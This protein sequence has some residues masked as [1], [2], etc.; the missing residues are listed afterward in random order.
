[1]PNVK[2]NF[3]YAGV[4][5]ALIAFV[6]VSMLTPL[7]ASFGITALP[8]AGWLCAVI[9]PLVL[10]LVYEIYKILYSVYL[11]ARRWKEKREM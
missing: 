4:I 8:A 1:M 7:G 10:L 6:A 5:A 9:P 3:I 2:F 11:S